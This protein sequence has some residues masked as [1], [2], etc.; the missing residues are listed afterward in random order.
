M[1]DFGF[2]LDFID[3]HSLNINNKKELNRLF[4]S[5][6][7][8]CYIY[9]TKKNDLT[10]EN[11][12]R[13]ES[14][15][16]NVSKWTNSNK[17]KFGEYSHK[18]FDVFKSIQ[19]DLKNI[20]DIV[21][22][23]ITPIHN[24]TLYNWLGYFKSSDA[25]YMI[26]GNHKI[27]NESTNKIDD[28]L[29]S[30]ITNA[31]KS[32]KT[33][34][35]AG[36][37]LY[38]ISGQ[39]SNDYIENGTGDYYK[40][41]AE[42]AINRKDIDLIA[43]SGVY[44][45]MVNNNNEKIILFATINEKTDGQDVFK[46]LR[47]EKD[48]K[49]VFVFAPTFNQSY[50]Y[51][52]TFYNGRKA[53]QHGTSFLKH[54]K[55]DFDFHELGDFNMLPFMALINNVEIPEN[56]GLKVTD[57]LKI[58]PFAYGTDTYSMYRSMRDINE[59]Y[60]PEKTEKLQEYFADYLLKI[61]TKLA[62]IENDFKL[63]D[64]TETIIINTQRII[65]GV[66]NNFNKSNLLNEIPNEKTLDKLFQVIQNYNTA[67]S[68]VDVE[69]SKVSTSIRSM[70]LK[71]IIDK[72]DLIYSLKQRNKT[73]NVKYDEI[74]L[75]KHETLNDDQE[76][77]YFEMFNQ[78]FNI[79]EAKA[80]RLVEFIKIRQINSKQNTFTQD[81]LSSDLYLFLQQHKDKEPYKVVF[82]F[83]EN[84]FDFNNPAVRDELFNVISIQKY[85]NSEKYDNGDVDYLNNL[86]C[87]NSLIKVWNILTDGSSHKINPTV[88][89][90]LN[91]IE[92]SGEKGLHV[93]D[94]YHNPFYK[95]QIR[96]KVSQP[97]YWRDAEK[98]PKTNAHK[99]LMIVLGLYDFTYGGK[100]T[101]TKE[102]LQT[103]LD[104][105]IS[106]RNKYKP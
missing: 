25:F 47:K 23:L 71:K 34:K 59:Y 19:T 63:D 38:I 21:S 43:P 73:I 62:T 4:N 72:D 33:E 48:S 18:Y 28:I 88:I 37:H 13:I 99:Q 40:Q 46:V 56:T 53:E 66:L 14:Y 57:F 6:E 68:K 45:G 26:K 3:M 64:D 1:S 78:A 51:I 8:L 97:T 41:K 36:Y 24:H 96:G 92:Q 16:I 65:L 30:A 42:L 55:S 86:H 12:E 85:E 50:S 69:N 82:K 79:P 39:A 29:N 74:K 60:E 83:I 91:K 10:Q 31:K 81:I 22:K 76:N 93:N 100:N 84:G 58:N 94:I 20:D 70:D 75:E 105:Y 15:I 49:I 101:F 54:F 27:Q 9:E 11:K 102:L 89:E 17:D 80:S 106:A 95:L 104:N 90:F 5:I 32:I 98:S 61:T 67:V 77:K 44:D 52:D 103:N 2:E 7:D 35:M 87:K